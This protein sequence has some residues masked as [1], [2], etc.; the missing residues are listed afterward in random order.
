[1][2]ITICENKLE[3]GYQAAILGRHHIKST[4][5][6]KGAANIAFVTG[7]SQLEMLKSLRA[8]DIDWSKV[9]VF[10]L[11]EFIGI[12]DG[13]KASSETFLKENFLAYLPTIGSFHPISRDPDYRKT[14]K[15][16]N[17]L[18]KDY[19]IDVAF[20]CIGENGHLAFNDPP[21]DFDATDPYIVVDLEK[22]SK[23]QQVSEGWFSS[24]DEVPEKA[25]TMSVHEILSSRIIVCACPDQRKAKAVASCIFD[26]ITPASPCS[27]IRRRTEC[28]IFLDRQSSR[29]VFGDGREI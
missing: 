13:H 19:P 22:R 8:L 6:K 26:D 16:M 17:A 3:L 9:N 7:T 5:L 28:T 25:I 21:A 23:R 29:L 15:E 20:I 1:M 27:S 4:I 14:L 10:L 12:P 18:M 2:R 24:I 11:D